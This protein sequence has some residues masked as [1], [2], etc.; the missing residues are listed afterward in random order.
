MRFG[1]LTVISRAPSNTKQ[2]K[3]NCLCDCGNYIVTYAGM[4][5]SG[6][7]KKCRKCSYC[8]YSFESDYVI[9][10]TRNNNVFYFSLCDYDLLKNYTWNV[11]KDGYVV[12]YIG[13]KMIF[14][15]RLIMEQ[16]IDIK[17]YDIDHINQKKNDNKRKNLRR[18]TRQENKRNVTMIKTNTTGYKGVYKLKNNGVET[19]R[20][21]ARIRIDKNKILHLGCFSNVE[22]AVK[23]REEAELKYFGEFSPLKCK[24]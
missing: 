18:A 6:D 5:I 10:K 16:L 3:W 8:T 24:V 2:A 20:Y 9:G 1:K 11:D 21:Y 23:A 7:I 15:H 4:L 22:D 17:N 14:M 13:K 19:G 12:T